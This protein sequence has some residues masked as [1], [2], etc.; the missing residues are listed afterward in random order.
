MTLENKLT[1]EKMI[2]EINQLDD[3]YAHLKIRR[4]PSSS[5]L[6][7]QEMWAMNGEKLSKIFIDMV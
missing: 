3:H 5:V 6:S 7:L 1:N 2:I 4:L